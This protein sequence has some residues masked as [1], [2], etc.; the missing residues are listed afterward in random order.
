MLGGSVARGFVALAARLAPAKSVNAE[1]TTVA[2]PAPNT[3]PAHSQRLFGE[4]ITF[5]T[6]FL[7]AR[8]KESDSRKSPS[9]NASNGGFAQHLHPE[10][11]LAPRPS[12]P[13]GLRAADLRR[14]GSRVRT[15]TRPTSGAPISTSTTSCMC[16]ARS[17][18]SASSATSRGPRR[19]SPPWS[20]PESCDARED[21][22]STEEVAQMN[23]VRARD[24]QRDRVDGPNLHDHDRAAENYEERA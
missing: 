22:D 16:S 14:A 3:P 21:D 20:C 19:L 10:R 11:L 17:A 13:Y 7:S 15:R 18:P 23:S 24:G 12:R 8:W 1:T 4:D 6:P 5:L 2:T 9:R